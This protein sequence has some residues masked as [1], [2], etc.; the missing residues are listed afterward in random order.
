MEIFKY[1]ITLY[2]FFAALFGAV[3]FSVA[4]SFPHLAHY[5]YSIALLVHSFVMFGLFLDALRDKTHKRSE[6]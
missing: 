1:I 5:A 6:K 3:S 4:L 2:L